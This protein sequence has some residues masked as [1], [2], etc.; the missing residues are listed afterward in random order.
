MVGAERAESLDVFVAGFAGGAGGDVVQGALRVDRVVE[1][2][3]VDDQAERAE[4]FFLALAVG[5]AQFAAA[6]MADISRQSVAAFAAVELDEDAPPELLVVAVVQEVDRLG[7][8]A[9]VLQR[10]RKRREVARVAAQ[11]AHELA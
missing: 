10:P 7:G 5:L 9:D 4:L 11:R 1:D 2:D 6:A 8:S 3:R